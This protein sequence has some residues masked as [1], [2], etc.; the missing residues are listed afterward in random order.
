MGVTV[1]NKTLDAKLDAIVRQRVKK[2]AA[3]IQASL[4]HIANG[5]PL[6]AEPDPKRR[7]ARLQAK[8]NY[9]AEALVRSIDIAARQERTK[10]TAKPSGQE[11]VQG[12]TLD[13]VGIAFFERGRRVAD[14][15]ARIAY[16]NGRPQGSGFMVAPGL[17]LTNHHVIETE[18]AAA[19]LCVEF[20][21]EIDANNM[22]RKV[23][24][25]RLNPA[26][27]FVTDGIEGLDYTLVALGERISGERMAAD[28]G[29]VPLSDAADKHMLGEV[30][31]IIQHPQ[32]RHKEVV[33]RENRLVAR[34]ET[35]NVLH[36]LADTEAG[37]SGSIVSNNDWEPIA[38]HHWAGP[39]R[40]VVS[41]K[42]GLPLSR[43][44]NEGIRISAIVKDLRRR[45]P[46]LKSASAAAVAGAL[47]LWDARR[48]GQTENIPSSNGS[49]GQ[50][51]A[52]ANGDGS[53]TWTFPVEISVRSPLFSP[54]PPD[55]VATRVPVVE[56]SDRQAERAA[57]WEAEDFSDRGGYEPGFIPGHI[58]PLPKIV[59]KKYR[60]AENQ[61]PVE[62]ADPHELP[63]H[64]F[65][66]VMNA[67]RR[68]A[69]FTAC[70]IDGARSKAINRDTK[71]VIDNPSLKDLGVESFGAEASDAFR[72]DRRILQEEQMQRPFY[73]S[74]VVPGYP[75]PQSRE[76]IAR[77]FQKGHITLRGDPAWGTQAQ[78]L[79]AEND[80]FFYTNA[81]PQ[82]GFFN[83]GSALNRPGSKGKLRWRAVETYV[84]RNAVTMR[85][86][87]CVFAGPV[88]ADSD[89]DYRFDSKIPMKF[90]KIAIWAD[91]EDS[92]LRAIALL[93]DQSSVLKKKNMPEAFAANPE[94]YAEDEE[95][96]R[97]TE[98][99]STVKEIE[100]LTGLDFG[101][102][103]HDADIRKGAKPGTPALRLQ[104]ADLQ[105]GK[106][107]RA[108]MKKAAKTKTA[109]TKTASKATG[110]TTPK[111]RTARKNR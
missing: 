78:A 96:A 86:R 87:I 106:A 55:N 11:A 89:P 50:P 44:V 27:C 69:F 51:G 1:T 33:V 59:S 30:A 36:Y 15:V 4:G 63:Y 103:L 38:L 85:Q 72:P 62:G 68:L 81:A 71:T 105:S 14:A 31:N 102:A 13:F 29:Y 88:F 40:E 19:E 28:F 39:A 57:A 20:D 26:R 110:K 98:F 107:R 108:S 75:D 93:A 22:A 97:V 104:P 99:L 100:G 60:I 82:I 12:P 92:K 67:D 2:A 66:I 41:T 8:T 54:S 5:N 32:G 16:G 70:N 48:N 18:A 111:K 80:T 9:Q 34:D 47:K 42:D 7:F 3:T 109:K 79:A 23:T 21:Y 58:V 25:Y 83:Q 52:R 74:Q 65:S 73:E 95:L 94:A 17:I 37:A 84:L 101:K 46:R 53:I 76:R 43:Q 91:N 10:A 64:H 77:M 24:R 6:A 35:V 49:G 90:W 45:Q 61:E 56:R